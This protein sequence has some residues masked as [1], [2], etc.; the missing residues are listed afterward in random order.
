[1]DMS[2]ELNLARRLDTWSNVEARNPGLNG[3][4]LDK[5]YAAELS[6]VI[7]SCVPIELVTRSRLETLLG[8][9]NKA[10]E[11][12]MPAISRAFGRIVSLDEI[13]R[14]RASLNIDPENM[15]MNLIYA[16]ACAIV[17]QNQFIPLELIQKMKV[18]T[19]ELFVGIG[20]GIQQ[21]IIDVLE[22]QSAAANEGAPCQER[23]T[24]EAHSHS[25][26]SRIKVVDSVRPRGRA[27]IIEFERKAS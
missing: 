26:H 20:H 10:D 27:Q 12:F 16:E 22:S 15:D 4:G 8:I 5:L 23:S 13:K 18:P 3:T 2:P 1:M 21:R 6:H 9:F 14:A 11:L 19:H 7:G 25:D 24:P 17:A